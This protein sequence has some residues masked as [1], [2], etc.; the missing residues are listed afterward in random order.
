M[1][2]PGFHTKKNSQISSTFRNLF[3]KNF[4]L[5]NLNKSSV[6]FNTKLNSN[7][8]KFTKNY[9]SPTILETKYISNSNNEHKKDDKLITKLYDSN[10][11]NIIKMIPYNIN[12]SLKLENYNDS[13]FN[14][15]VPIGIYKKNQELNFSTKITESNSSLKDIFYGENKKVINFKLKYLEI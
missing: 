8:I 7:K 6:K 12:Q 3:D 11:K 4:N 14:K 5:N 9:I 1:Y 10:Y 2:S 15:Q 13:Y